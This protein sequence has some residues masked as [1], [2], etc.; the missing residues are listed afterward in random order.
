[1]IN[2]LEKTFEDGQV[3]SAEEMNSVSGKIDEIIGEVNLSSVG[4]VDLNSDGT[5]EI[6]NNYS[7]EDLNISK[8]N[9]SHAEG[10]KTQANS[11]GSHAE[12]IETVAGDS[13][14]PKNGKGAHAEG[15]VTT[16]L[17]NG[18]HAEGWKTIASGNYSHTEG[19]DSI[20]SGENSHAEGYLGISSG[21]GSHVEGYGS[22]SP[23]SVT[24][25]K[26]GSNNKQFYTTAELNCR[27]FKFGGKTY[28]VSF[29]SF[30]SVG[31]YSVNLLE[32]FTTTD[33]E[34][35][36]TRILL[37]AYGKGSHAEGESISS[38]G[39]S[40]S[41]GKG[42][43]ADGN[44]SHA[45]GWESRATG[46]HSHA[47]GN[48][49]IASGNQSHSEGYSTKASGESSHAEGN[50]TKSEGIYSHSEG[51]GTTA[52]GTS[53]HAEGNSTKAEGENSHAEGNNTTASENDSH[54]E[55]NKTIA[56]GL[57]S[58]AEGLQSE[59]SGEA[60][61]VEGKYNKSKGDAS[62]AEGNLTE[63]NGR[64]THSEGNL[65]Y[66][67]GDSSHAEG[68]ESYS[69]GWYSHSQNRGNVAAN[70]AQTSIGSYSIT[71]ESSPSVEA[72][73]IEKEAFTIGNGQDAENRSN[74]FK[75]LFNGKTYADGEYSGTGADYAEMFE[76]KDGNPEAEDRVGRFVTLNG[77]NIEL[78][79]SESTYI[80]GIV[81]G[82]PTIIGDNPIGWQGKYL[83][84]KWGRPVYEDVQ[85]KYTVDE[86]QE[87]GSIQKVE[88]T[89]TDHVRKINPDY[90]P[91]EKY[92][93]RSDR[94]EW[95]TIGLMGKLLVL[96]DGTLVAGSFCK[97]EEN[98]IATKSDSGYYV[99]EVLG[100]DQ[101]LIM[102]R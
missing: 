100:E 37:T 4:K 82:S 53:S 86:V 58:H 90:R 76:W 21:A 80:L 29:E 30:V 62:H 10:K 46:S 75:V 26:R 13:S 43:R 88:K 66:A 35:T 28:T 11:N 34:I 93:L 8:G 48:K 19:T 94:P 31:K 102:F 15:Q 68:N 78:A 96:Q 32:D 79:N 42:T 44:I 73:N 1:M 83:N 20:A 98:G 57:S 95:D 22:T 16:A 67:N 72:F 33:K 41:E 97:P 50:L 64:Y 101:A 25:T 6:F 49:T 51:S 99:M 23:L 17:G 54:A 27:F 71:D 38:G 2:K 91:E 14:N 7:G 3:L 84:D 9:S 24:F 61:H 5:G 56:S 74:A 40:H 92:T 36:I 69:N 45:E 47:E 52:S 81:S 18:A 39:H 89:R 60:S 65:S 12:G 87:D 55:G 59:S 63:A 77:K 70:Y 85:V